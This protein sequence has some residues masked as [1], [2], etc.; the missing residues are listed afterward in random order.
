MT[1]DD[2][3]EKQTSEE[4][5]APTIFQVFASVSAAFFGVQSS[6][7]KQRDFKHGNHKVFIVVGLCMTAI[8]LATV[9]SIVQFVLSGR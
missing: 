5:K 2:S 1:N 8:F 7:N 9:I 3:T 4:D 6:K